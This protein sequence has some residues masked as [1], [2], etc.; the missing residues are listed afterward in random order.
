MGG[1]RVH[2]GGYGDRFIAVKVQKQVDAVPRVVQIDP[3]SACIF[4]FTP[5]ET[6]SLSMGA[7]Y[8]PR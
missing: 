3:A 2:P 8:V 4:L 5:Q 7:W 1:R 6:M